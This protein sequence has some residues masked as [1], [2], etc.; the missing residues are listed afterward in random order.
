M[1]YAALGGMLPFAR[2]LRNL[3]NAFKLHLRTPDRSVRARRFNS[4][5][6]CRVAAFERAPGGAAVASKAAARD[7]YMMTARVLAIRVGFP[8]VMRLALVTVLARSG[9]SLTRGRRRFG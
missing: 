2:I 5:M 6:R 4:L 9:Y 7:K 3:A 8:H 1:P